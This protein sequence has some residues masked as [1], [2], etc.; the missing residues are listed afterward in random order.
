MASPT[1]RVVSV[2][3]AGLVVALL[4]VGFVSGTFLRHIVQILPIIVAAGALTRRPDWGAYAAVPIFLFWIFIV[5]LIWLFL[6]DLSQIASGHYTLIEIVSTVFMAGFSVV[7]VLR[8]IQLGKTL[9]PTGRA[10][11]VSLFGALQVVA[12]W[13]SFLKP[14]A[15]R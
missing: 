6:L 13:V 9:R 12:M 11:A 10:L 2:C 5:V 4:V 1:Q 15:N 3:L 8:S 14:I 7:G